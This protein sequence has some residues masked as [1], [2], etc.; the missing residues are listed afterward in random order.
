MSQSS[1][2]HCSVFNPLLLG[3]SLPLSHGVVLAPLTRFRASALNVPTP[4]NVI[5]YTQRAQSVP[6]TLLITEG[7]FTAAKAT[8]VQYVPGIW[9]DEQIEGWRQVANAVHDVGGFAFMQ[10]FAPGRGVFASSGIPKADWEENGFE[11]VSSSAVSLSGASYTPRAMSVPEIHEFIQLFGQ[12]AH[13][14]VHEAGLDGVE[15]HGANGYLIDQFT[16]DT[17][18][19]RTDEYGGSIENRCRFALE[20]VS[21]VCEAIGESKTGL[22]LSPWSRFQG[23]NVRP[24]DR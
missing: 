18:N 9:N 13:N 7:T 14:A 22:R 1:A 4:L 21:A 8:E 23:R 15:I 11:Y 17:S 6:G 19:T 2:T 10:L 12:A 5:Y 24:C 3:P 20:I 16:Q